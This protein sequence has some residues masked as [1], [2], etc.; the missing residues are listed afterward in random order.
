MGEDDEWMMTLIKRYWIKDKGDYGYLCRTRMIP[1]ESKDIP[2]NYSLQYYWSG[3]IV[4][5]NIK[6]RVKY[7]YPFAQL[8]RA[9][10][11]ISGI[12]TTL[13]EVKGTEDE[14]R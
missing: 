10:I 4:E 3:Y 12:R 14:V 1:V 8:L 11:F 7:L 2:K 9:T 6:Q 5:H 13:E